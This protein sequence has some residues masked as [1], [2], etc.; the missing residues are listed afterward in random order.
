MCSVFQCAG[1][2]PDAVILFIILLTGAANSGVNSR[3]IDF[4][5]SSG[6]PERGFFAADIAKYTSYS[7]MIGGFEQI[8]SFS[9]TLIG[10][11]S[12][13]SGGNVW[14]IDAK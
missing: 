12:F 2:S 6:T 3:I 8:S 5:R 4:G 11:L 9:R 7:D 10:S 14:L 13:S 1:H